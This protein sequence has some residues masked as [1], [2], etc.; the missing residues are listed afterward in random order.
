MTQESKNTI[1]SDFQER[2]QDESTGKGKYFQQIVL[3]HIYTYIWK[4]AFRM[5]FGIII[6]KLH[7]NKCYDNTYI[8][9]FDVSPIIILF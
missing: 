5:Y 1:Q 4:K 8:F 6:K 2:L 9:Y 7:Y 3:E